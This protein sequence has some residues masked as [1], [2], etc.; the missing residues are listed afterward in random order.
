MF[1]YVCVCI[2]NSVGNSLCVCVCVSKLTCVV[3]TC[4]FA[5][6]VLP[7]PL[8]NSIGNSFF[9]VCLRVCVCVCVSKLTRVVCTCVCLQSQCC[10]SHYGSDAGKLQSS[11]QP[12]AK[13]TYV[14]CCTHL[15][16]THLHYTL[17]Y[18]ALSHLISPYLDLRLR[19][20]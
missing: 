13:V 17:P 3:Y 14:S 16:P 5:E 20:H 1:V 2:I 9:F 18:L 10:Q 12:N 6:P 19:L 7:I 8:I 15:I 11:L 4:V